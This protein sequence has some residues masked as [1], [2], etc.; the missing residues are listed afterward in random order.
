MSYD[1]ANQRA[2][3]NHR[4]TGTEWRC[5]GCARS[6]IAA[7]TARSPNGQAKARTVIRR[8]ILVLPT[9]GTAAELL[10]CQCVTD[11]FAS[12]LGPGVGRGV[13]IEVAGSRGRGALRGHHG[14]QQA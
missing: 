13:D 1:R 10:G 11:I 5:F 4:A 9:L 2:R 3:S 14:D 6:E 8:P 12:V 7:D